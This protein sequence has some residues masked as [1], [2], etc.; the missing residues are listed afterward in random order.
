MGSLTAGGYL[1]AEWDSANCNQEKSIKSY[2]HQAEVRM[3]DVLF[4]LLRNF[5]QKPIP[6]YMLVF[7]TGRMST[8]AFANKHKPPLEA[9]SEF[10]EVFNTIKSH[11]ASVHVHSSLIHHVIHVIEIL[12][13]VHLSEPTFFASVHLVLCQNNDTAVPLVNYV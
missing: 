7:C 13:F 1:Y 5:N 6:N 12:L 8:R 11:Q 10:M 4:Y 2:T 3:S 9:W